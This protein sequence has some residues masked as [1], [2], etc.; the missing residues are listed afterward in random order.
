MY[1]LK[2]KIIKKDAEG[3]T[4]VALVVT[5][6]I[7]LILAGIAINL[8]LGE[9]GIFKK[10]GEGAQIYQNASN[11]EKI[12]IDKVSNYIDDYLNGNKNE[13]N[14]E[15]KL[16]EVEE[17]IKNGTV[18]K[19]NT[20][21][22][23]EYKNPI[24]VPAGFKIAEDSG[25]DV[26]KGVVIEDVQAGDE[27]SKGNQY[28]WVPIGNVKY[29]ISGE[30]KTINLGRYS[31]D[32]K[33][34][35]ETDQIEGTGRE[36]LMQSADNYTSTV[37]IEIYFQELQSSSYEN[38]TAKNL[39]DFITKAENAG[40]Y[41]LGRYEAGKVEDN[42]ET[43]NVKKGQEVYNNITQPNAATLARD[44]Y[45]SNSNFQS[46]LINSYAWDTAIVFIQTFSGDSDYSKQISLQGTLAT[47][48]N[49][50]DS[51]NNYDIRCNI[52]DMA[53][54]VL[55]WVTETGTYSNYPCVYRGGNYNYSIY[56]T[57]SR[58]GYETRSSSPYIGFRPTLY[59]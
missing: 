10:A 11:N 32:A 43:F 1:K 49:A 27:I 17:S 14:E 37:A 44:L 34:N 26:T 50:H 35:E 13:D 59:L 20:T 23:D 48:G 38:A 56:F 6:I 25:T 54:N 57:S 39:G 4:L 30:Y 22:Y 2:E 51:N 45:S 12:E 8:T 16:S 55:E 40:G 19:T 5:I 41:Y 29:N 46:D 52:Y 21:I 58:N 31:F 53:G 42:T 47:T 28:V 24:K 33:Y 36:T 18:Y 15:E 3:I 9:D 7:L